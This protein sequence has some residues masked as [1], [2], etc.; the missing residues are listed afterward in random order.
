MNVRVVIDPDHDRADAQRIGVKCSC[1][2]RGD[3]SPFLV[4][5]C[6]FSIVHHA[7]KI[8]MII[9]RPSLNLE[10]VSLSI[11]DSSVEHSQ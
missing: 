9:S 7:V 5:E 2:L 11:L 3:A 4:S 6:I 8:I 10:I 1:R